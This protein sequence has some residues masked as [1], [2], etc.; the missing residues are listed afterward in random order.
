MNKIT[1]VTGGARSGKSS[2]AL[3]AAVS[4]RG[5]RVFVATAIAFDEEMSERIARHKKERADAFATIEEAVDLAGAMNALPPDTE[6]A[7][8]DC[9]TVWLGNLFHSGTVREDSDTVPEIEMF[10]ETVK[11]ASCDLIIVTNEVGMGI[12]PENPMARRFRDM[13]GRLNRDVAVAAD[14]VILLVSG[15]P[16]AIKRSQT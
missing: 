11:T 15:I 6:V 14:E 5:P 4:H 8:V 13:A 7:V 1:L 2:Y 12:V 16:V 9:L 10:L 3:Q